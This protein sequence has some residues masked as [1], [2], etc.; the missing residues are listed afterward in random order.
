MAGTIAGTIVSKIG[1]FI[2]DDKNLTLDMDD[3]DKIDRLKDN[4]V[5]P[6]IELPKISLT[7]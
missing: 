1:I 2:P 6:N 5:T 3:K 7:D 4:S